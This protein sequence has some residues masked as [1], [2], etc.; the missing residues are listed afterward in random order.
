MSRHSSRARSVGPS[1]LLASLC[2]SAC[3]GG[4]GGGGGGSGSSNSPWL[5]V[6][7]TQLEVTADAASS[8]TPTGVVTVTLHNGSPNGNT[9]GARYSTNAI[10][11]VDFA[12]AGVQGT[13]TISFVDPSVIGVG[14]YSDTLE[15]AICK[16]STCNEIEN[17]T[18]VTVPITY[19]VSVTATVTLSANPQLTGAGVP[20]T[21][22]WSSTN[23]NSCT[24]SGEWSGTLPSSG[25]QVVTPQT[26][27]NHTYTLT[28]AN[29]GAPGE[30][31]I[32]VTALSPATT[33][34]AFPTHV[35]LGKPVTLRWK[36]QYA[37]SCVAS[38]DWSGPLP[39]EG[40]RTLALTELGIFDFHLDCSNNADSAEADASV[41]VTAAP[42]AAPATAYR[43]SAMHDGV[44]VTSNGITHPATTAPTWTR[45]FG[46]PVSY[47]LIADGKVFIATANPD[48]SYGNMLYALNA[49]TGATVWGPIAVP[50]TYFGSG[51]TYDDGR[52]FIL[53]FDGALRAFNA[54]N[55]AP[56]WTTQLPGYW[57]A[58]SPNAYGGMVF[59]NG[60]GGLSALDETTGDI[61]WT[62]LR[63]GT[64]GWAS[65]AVASEG[66]YTQAG[67][68]NAGAYH[69]V[70][71]EALWEERSPCDGPWDFAPVIKNGIFF[72]RT[73]SSLNLFDAPTGDFLL[74]LGSA[75][76]P[77][78]TDTAVLSVY[79]GILSSTRLG[80]YV[81]TWAFAGDGDLVTA[82][83]VVNDL[84]FIGSASGEV[85][86][87]D[88]ET[89]VEVW[90]GLSPIPIRYDSENGGPMPPSGPAAGE[91]M[92]VFPAGNSVAAWRLQ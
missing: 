15:V 6:S 40:F 62:T 3:G 46:A 21:L 16:D 86:G 79:S 43:M 91:D 26:L 83:V 32:I 82:P 34:T 74:Q 90:T 20:T 58:A 77:A 4:G 49:Q 33:L 41:T 44:L 22:T 31:S 56:L 27:G 64:T 63:A 53:M 54:A 39:A 38:G 10:R 5:T 71:G 92:L 13:L 25:S 11:N 57:Y 81:Q 87:L 28:C 89:G 18:K 75:F 59:V 17:S 61:L 9:V 60:N 67:T 68:C 37:A 66:I 50:G 85:H 12:V 2:L 47:P 19:T 80:D 78:V 51:L 65:P 23:A 84:V 55:G 8:Y 29:P 52:I 45:D 14:T 72:G 88:V 7:P 73:G 30:A 70:I 24:A 1:L 69:P 42:A 48:G 76:A 36:G 35:V